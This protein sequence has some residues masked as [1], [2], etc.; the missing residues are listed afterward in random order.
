MQWEIVEHK[1]AQNK[2]GPG[3]WLEVAKNQ[4]PLQHF[5]VCTGVKC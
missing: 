3:K 4:E 1:I 5:C 2:L